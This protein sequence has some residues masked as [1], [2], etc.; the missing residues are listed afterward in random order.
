MCRHKWKCIEEWIP[1]VVAI[2]SLGPTTSSHDDGVLLDLSDREFY[3]ALALN[4][5]ESRGRRKVGAGQGFPG[6]QGSVHLFS[7]GATSSNRVWNIYK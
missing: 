2:G 3:D 1:Q 7:G 4:A 6:V 5:E